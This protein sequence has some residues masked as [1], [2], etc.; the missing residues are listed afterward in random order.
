MS[1]INWKIVL[2]LSLFGA[3]VGVVSVFVGTASAR[4]DRLLWLPAVLVSA[5]VIARFVGRSQFGNGAVVGFIAGAVAKL[6]QGIFAAAYWEHNPWLAEAF[7]DKGPEFDFQRYTLN[8][9]PYVGVANALVQG[10]LA[11]IAGRVFKSR[12][13]GQ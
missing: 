2:L 6:V 3:A 12:G 9:V 7:A 4:A 13:A 1:R 11:F 5:W 8:L 10:F